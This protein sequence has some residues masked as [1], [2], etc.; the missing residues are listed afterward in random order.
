MEPRDD[1]DQGPPPVKRRRLLRISVKSA[2]LAA[3]AAF[4]GVFVYGMFS[5]GVAPGKV[6]AVA[7]MPEGS[8]QMVSWKGRP[9]WI[10][11]RSPA[12]LEALTAASGF[13]SVSPDGNAP[14]PVDGP[15]RSLTPEYGVYLANTGR[16]GVLVQYTA[17]RPD[18]LAADATWRGGF[19]DPGSR[20]VFDLAGRRYTT[21]TGQPLAVPPHRLLDNGTLRLGQW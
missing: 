18:G 3:V 9:V 2:L 20:A 7:E 17:E 11:R 4:A 12:Q 8:A 19:V 10:V 1:G 21:T 14:D 5:P 13:V 15:Y 16:S 6:V